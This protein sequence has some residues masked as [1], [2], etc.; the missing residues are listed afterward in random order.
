MHT[1]TEIDTNTDET[2]SYI[3]SGL[4]DAREVLGHIAGVAKADL[5][6]EDSTGYSVHGLLTALRDECDDILNKL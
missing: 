5:T 4:N 3:T 1:D 6:R 2:I